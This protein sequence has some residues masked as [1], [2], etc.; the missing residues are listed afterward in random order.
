M[1]GRRGRGGLLGLGGGGGDQGIVEVARRG[2]GVVL[3]SLE[4]VL[5]RWGLWRQFC[6]FE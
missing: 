2:G 3:G 5:G 4:R 6:L 1:E